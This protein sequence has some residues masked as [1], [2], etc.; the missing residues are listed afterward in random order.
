LRPIQRFFAPAGHSNSGI[1]GGAA[2]GSDDDWVWDDSARRGREFVIAPRLMGD[3][4]PV[5]GPSAPANPP[6]PRSERKQDRQMV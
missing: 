6:R 5:I 3:H 4:A 1:G 2:P